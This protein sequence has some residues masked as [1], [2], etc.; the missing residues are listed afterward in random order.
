MRARVFFGGPRLFGAE[1]GKHRSRPGLGASPR[2]LFHAK[3]HASAVEEPHTLWNE[4]TC[5]VY[6]RACRVVVGAGYKGM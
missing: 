4:I 2:V 3:A 6:A 1:K 5:G